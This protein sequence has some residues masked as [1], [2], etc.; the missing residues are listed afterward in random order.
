VF[1][2]WIQFRS[3]TPCAETVETVSAHTFRGLNRLPLG[4]WGRS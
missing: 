1:R 3:A 4:C 2:Q